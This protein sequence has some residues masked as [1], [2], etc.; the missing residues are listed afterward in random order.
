MSWPA[1]W[2]VHDL[3]K[4]D[5]V[6]ISRGRRPQRPVKYQRIAFL[7]R[8]GGV[9]GLK[10]AGVV[11]K[12]EGTVALYSNRVC[13]AL[14]NIRKQHV[15]WP[16]KERR[17]FLK[18]EMAE[19]GFPGCLGMVDGSLIRLRER[20]LKSPWSFFCRKK[21]YAFLI[22]A[23][24]DHRGIIIEYELGWPG[25][26]A[27]TMAFK[28]S[29]LWQN[30]G[31]YFEDDE[32]VL[33]DK[34]YPLTKFT[35]RPFAEHDMTTDPQEVRQRRRFNITL[36]RLRVK[37]E[38]AF[39][40]L[41]GRFVALREFPGRSLQQMW[42]IIESLIILHNILTEYGDDPSEIEGF[43]GEEDEDE[44]EAGEDAWRHYFAILVTIC[45]GRSQY[46]TDSW[47]ATVWS[48]FINAAEFSEILGD[49]P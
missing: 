36:S 9:P 20:P 23:I 29:E 2:H 49:G 28:E 43:N 40:M 27:D 32:Y 33:A 16:G 10:A 13:Q 15:F 24:C 21:F 14:R 26:V 18:K 3:I 34:G 38:H 44:P 4:D 5:P 7:V 11:V 37:V 30:R 22:Q 19:Y 47:H 39:G 17:A 1:F 48:M 31:K 42:R 12:S 6:F 8:F 46:F 35:T 41:K 45:E 25:S